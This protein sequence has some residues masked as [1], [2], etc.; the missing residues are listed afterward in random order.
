MISPHHQAIDRCPWAGIEDPEYARY[1]DEEWGVPKTADRDLLRKNH[2]RRVPGRPLVADHP[3]EARQLPPR[4]PQFRSRTHRPLHRRRPCPPDGRCGHR[5]QPPQNRRHHRQCPRL[6]KARRGAVPVALHL[7][8]ISTAGRSSITHVRFANV[9]AE[10]RSQKPSPRPSKSAA[11]VLLA[12][13]RS[14]PSCR[15]A[16]SSTTIW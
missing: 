16:A 4:L 1:H 5:P 7:G 6:P 11:F 9:P 10:T 13:P 14:T 15:Q 8:H 3:K 12:Q 2:P